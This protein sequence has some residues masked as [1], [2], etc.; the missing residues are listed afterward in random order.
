MFEYV[1]N[2]EPGGVSYFSGSRGWACDN[3]AN[4][5]VCIGERVSQDTCHKLKP[6]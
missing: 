3:I 1:A 4:Y 2:I 6:D 5:E